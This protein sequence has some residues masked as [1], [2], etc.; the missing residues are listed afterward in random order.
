MRLHLSQII[1][2][3]CFLNKNQNKF[4]SKNFYNR[5]FVKYFTEIQF[6]KLWKAIQKIEGYKIGEIIE[7]YRI[8]GVKILGSNKYQYCLHEGEWIS[9]AE[10]IRLAMERKVELEVCESKLGNKFLRTPPNSL[11]QEN[12]WI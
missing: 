2:N 1:C 12:F 4:W 11:F 9:E 7:V 10:C 5:Y 6:E 3:R 8:S